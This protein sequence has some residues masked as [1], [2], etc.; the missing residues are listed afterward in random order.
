MYGFFVRRDKK[1]GRCREGLN[2]SQCMDFLSAGTNKSGSYR[3]VAVVL[4]QV[5]AGSGSTV[6]KL[7]KILLA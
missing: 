1:R 6:V 5:A 4:R 7:S 3:G 2:K